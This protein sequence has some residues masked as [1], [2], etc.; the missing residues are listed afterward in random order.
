M[1]SALDKPR[2]SRAP[3]FSNV[4]STRPAVT[5]HDYV[6][7][8][9]MESGNV[10]RAAIY[11]VK[12]VRYLAA[13][14]DFFLESD[15]VS[16]YPPTPLKVTRSVANPTP[17]KVTRS[18]A[19][20]TPLKVTRSVAIRPPLKVTRSVAIPTPLKVTRSVAIRPPLKVTRSVAI[21]PPL[22]V[23]RS[24]ANPTPLKVTRSVAIP[25]PLKVTR[26]V[27]IRP[28][29]KVTRSVAIPTPLKVTRSVAIRP[30]LKVTRSVAIRPPLKVTRSV[31]NPPSLESDQ[32]QDLLKGFEDSTGL[33]REGLWLQ[34][35]RYTLTRVS[36]RRIMV[37]RD[38]TTGF[39]C[40]LYRCQS[41][42]IVACYEDGNH[43]GACYTLVTRLGD[44]LV[45][46]GF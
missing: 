32:V 6:H 23:T 41:C 30:P 15:Q 12:D 17:L 5:W 26:S 11:R 44:F 7:V 21:R 25:T 28:P 40:V 45:D 4:N 1:L 33:R 13:T 36:D 42:L 22:K 35:D 29:L 43:P 3:S 16:G 18:V 38:E 8:L 37:G 9:L 34:D 10:S 20:P 39:G 46:S 19:I 27:A 14:E 31:A 2:S 24:V